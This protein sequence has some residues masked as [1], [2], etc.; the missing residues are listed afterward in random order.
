MSFGH[1]IYTPTM[2]YQRQ[3]FVHVGNMARS[4]VRPWDRGQEVGQGWVIWRILPLP[5]STEDD[6]PLHHF[7]IQLR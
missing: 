3:G 4:D 6:E 5:V 2:D 7:Q 1:S